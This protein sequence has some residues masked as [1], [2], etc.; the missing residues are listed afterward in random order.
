[1]HIEIHLR[2]WTQQTIGLIM[3]KRMKNQK[4]KLKSDAI[5]RFHKVMFVSDLFHFLSTVNYFLEKKS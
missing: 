2:F 3:S 1:M 4:L 5:N